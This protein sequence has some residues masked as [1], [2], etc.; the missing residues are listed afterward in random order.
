MTWLIKAEMQRPDGN[1]EPV[2]I[3]PERI[4]AKANEVQLILHVHT[5]NPEGTTTLSRIGEETHTIV[6]TG[7]AVR[8]L[9]A[10]V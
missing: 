7:D 9:Q 8:E 3:I 6:L 1:A 4:H 5:N 10:A 2:T